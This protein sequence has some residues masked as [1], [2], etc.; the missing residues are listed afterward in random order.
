[1][2][3]NEVLIITSA[4]M[5]FSMVLFIFLERK[6]PYRK[7][8]PFFREGIWVDFIWYSLFQNFVLKIVIFDY[9]IH[10]V[11]LHFNLSRL[12]LVSDWPFIWQLVFFLVLHDLYIYWFHRWQ[13][14]SKIMWRTH[15]AHHSNKNV[16]WIA[17]SRSHALEIIINQTIEFLPIVLLGADPL[18]IPVKACIDGVWGMYI[19][20][21]IDV[22]SGKLQY[23]INGPEMHL[24]HHADE[25]VV[26]FANYSTKFAV[27]DWLFG[28]A[29]LPDTKPTKYGLYY[30]YPKDYF[31]Q[32]ITLFVRMDEKK[33]LENKYFR[34]YY[35]LRGLVMKRFRPT[36]TQVQSPE[37]GTP[38]PAFAETEKLN[39]S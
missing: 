16:D 25:N 15:E 8:L 34:A 27:W 36:P 13:H 22:K 31:I 6:F 24:W 33:L 3:E 28:T 32:F 18:I 26:F 9:I 19:H 35:G 37:A 30:E 12:Q 17:G 7:G 10:P 29:Y 5:L 23:F 39:I 11:D 21:N 20:S 14:N 2:S 38:P 1:V 4:I